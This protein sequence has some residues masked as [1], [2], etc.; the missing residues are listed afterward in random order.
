MVFTEEEVKKKMRDKGYILDKFLGVNEYHDFVDE[1]GYKYHVQLN[2]ILRKDNFKKFETFHVH[3]K[4]TIENIK[5]YIK[6]H[7]IDVKL[8]ST[9]Y[10]RNTDNLQFRCSCGNIFE[11]TWSNF[12]HKR[13]HN[14][15]CDEC[16]YKLKSGVREESKILNV[17]EHL[18]V[19]PIVPL[20]PNQPVTDKIDL[21]DDEGFLYYYKIQNLYQLQKVRVKNELDKVVV[22]NPYAIYNVNN[23][24][25]KCD[26]EFKCI[27]KKYTRNTQKLEIL[28]KECGTV[29]KM[30]WTDL[31]DMFRRN[32]EGTLIEH[33]PCCRKRKRE[34]YHASVL[35]Q[36]FIH[37]YPDT[38]LEEKGCVNPLTKYPLPTDIVNHRLKI[39]IEIQSSRHDNDYQQ[40]KDRIK[41]KY[42]QDKGYAFYDP[43]IRDYN[44]LELIQLFFPTISEIPKYINLKFSESLNCPLI[45]DYL[46]KGWSIKNIAKQL[47][48]KHASILSAIC[49]KRIVLPQNYKEDILNWIP[50]VQLDFDGNLLREFCSIGEANRQ[51]FTLAAIQRVLYSG[52]PQYKNSYWIKKRDYE[53][54]NYFIPDYNHQIDRVTKD[55]E[56]IKSYKNID[57]VQNELI[58]DMT[59]VKKAL[60]FSKT[61]RYNGEY[62]IIHK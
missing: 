7:N 56:I 54:G 33:C 6:L 44:V 28:H 4:Y 2:N 37:E 52:Q 3:N 22:S 23:F 42:W 27:S 48:I 18:G 9:E 43:D 47:G 30:P 35:K 29:F 31:Q 62:W 46:D 10:H 20:L 34:S 50:V 12:S 51:G 41:K 49:D 58:F 55:G 11:R 15:C 17:L 36:V 14:F 13:Q 39:A 32:R 59:E 16:S 38:V 19:T 8:V 57:E 21:I 5:H 53:Q 24:L 60:C 61:H 26:G 1:E 45:Q 40:T 25:K